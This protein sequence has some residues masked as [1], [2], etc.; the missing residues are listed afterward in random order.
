LLSSISIVAEF[1]QKLHAA[2][3]A[4]QTRSLVPIGLPAQSMKLHEVRAVIFDVYGTLVNYWKPE[5]GEAGAKAAHLVSVFRK[6][7][8]R[9]GMTD[10]L[11]HMNDEHSPEQTLNDLY[12]GLIALNHEK[13]R[14]K[15]VTFPEVRIEE[16]WMVILLMLKRHGFDPI[17]LALGEDREV[18]KCVAYYYNFH[19][20]GR[21]F[22]PG[23]VEALSTLKKH[24]I[25]LGIVSNA[26]FYTPI[27]LSLFARD[28][29]LGDVDDFRELFDDDLVVF[30]YEEGSAKPGPQLFRRLY[31]ALYEASILP[32]ETVFIG[33]D[34]VADV[35]PAQE[36]GMRTG[37]F[38]GDHLSAFV[39]DAWGSVA[40]DMSFTDWS[41][42][43]TVLEF[44]AEKGDAQ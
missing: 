12:H 18:A 17:P 15:G 2:E 4:P 22:Y 44:H 23:V 31:D 1:A 8:E 5:F 7:I 43:P 35:K 24:N 27:D 26:Q 29:G 25:R 6:T 40:P 11:R 34:L 39:H 38:A 16:V 36:A 3:S 30:S 33:N 28:Q 14:S 32:K 9:F 42:L 41:V 21:G 19:A 10:A 13:S 20:L 37:F